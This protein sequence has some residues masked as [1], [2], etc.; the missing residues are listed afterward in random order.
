MGTVTSRCVIGAC[1]WVKVA[2]EKAEMLKEYSGVTESI[3]LLF[4]MARAQCK[5]FS[6]LRGARQI[7]HTRK[8]E[9]DFKKGFKIREVFCIVICEAQDASQVGIA[10][11]EA[12]VESVCARR[13]SPP[14]Q[15]S[16]CQ[17]PPRKRR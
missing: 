8:G 7:R 17:Q 14:A 9:V 12:R 16:L 11:M 2:E 10:V 3:A 15:L 6:E 4:A 1:A 5:L 13:A